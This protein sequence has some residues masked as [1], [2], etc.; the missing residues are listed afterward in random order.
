M[1]IST[2]SELKTKIADTLNRDDLTSVI[3]DFIALA[4]S[5]INDDVKHWRGDK[6]AETTLDGQFI[7]LP[8]DWQETKR[9][10]LN[11]SGTTDLRYL[12]PETM[13]AMRASNNDAGGK[14]EYYT[15][16]AGQLELYPSPDA[17]YSADL[18]YR[19]SVSTLSDS[20]TDNWVLTN[21]PDV[22][23]YGALIHSAPYLVDDAR[24]QTWAALYSAAVKRVN[25]QSKKASASGKGLKQT[26]R[27]F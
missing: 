13:Q 4:E 21:Y 12:A 18:F 19:A 11:A 23:L 14:P 24:I 16:I 6:R 7:G 5:A 1:P 9:I 2:Y 20:N 25:K 15:H 8:S 22:Y 26:I 27:S 3:P 10:H 17:N